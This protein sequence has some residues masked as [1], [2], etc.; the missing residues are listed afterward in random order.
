MTHKPTTIVK[1]DR[2]EWNSAYARIRRV[3]IN[4][5]F[6]YIRVGDKKDSALT[7]RIASQR[8]RKMQK[9]YLDGRH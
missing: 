5:T 1:T 4:G 3:S 2:N 6:Y 9:E 8:A 7:L